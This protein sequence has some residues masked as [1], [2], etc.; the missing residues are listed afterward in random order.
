M[1]RDVS[2]ADLSANYVSV[3]LS[4]V[5]TIHYI[6]LHTWVVVS[7]GKPRQVLLRHIN[8]ALVNLADNTKFRTETQE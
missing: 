5:H 8:D 7:L 3:C 1:R 2:A 6:H 4:T